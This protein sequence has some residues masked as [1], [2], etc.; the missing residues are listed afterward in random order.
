VWV[1]LVACVWVCLC[2]VLFFLFYEMIR[3]SRACSR[4][5]INVVICLQIYNSIKDKEECVKTLTTRMNNDVAINTRTLFFIFF[6][7]T[8]DIILRRGKKGIM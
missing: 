3:I 4:K 2:P 1:S 8:Q 7:I 5:R 6:T